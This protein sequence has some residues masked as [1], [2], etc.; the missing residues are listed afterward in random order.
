MIFVTGATGFLGNYLLRSLAA[1]RQP[2]R[3]LVRDP[4]KVNSQLHFENVEWIQGDV[5]DVASLESAMT[6]VE[7]I[8][9]CAAMVS[10]DSSD[11]DTMMRVNATG[12]ANVVNAALAAGV[13]KLLHVSS[14]A[15]LGRQPRAERIDENAV[16]KKNS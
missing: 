10:F 1:S 9:H 14:T 11:H 3:A 5:L 7:K 13:K 6:G 16:W 8:Y 2:V 15:A 12:T 4:A